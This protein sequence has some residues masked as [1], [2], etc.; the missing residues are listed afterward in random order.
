MASALTGSWVYII[1]E[2]NHLKPSHAKKLTILDAG[3]QA[4]KEAGTVLAQPELEARRW[5]GYRGLVAPQLLGSW[6][7]AGRAAA[8]GPRDAHVRRH[9]RPAQPPALLVLGEALTP[10]QDVSAYACSRLCHLHD[11]PVCIR[12]RQM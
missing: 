8:G 4:D 6:E 12:V 5:D 10:Q 1:V 9:G 11:F 2:S 3:L 7:L